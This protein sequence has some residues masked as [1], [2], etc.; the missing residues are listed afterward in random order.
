MKVVKLNAYLLKQD[1]SMGSFAKTVGTTTATISRI[2]DGIVVPRKELMQRIHSA[3]HGAVIP[4]DLV[5]LH[6]VNP[7]VPF[8]QSASSTTDSKAHTDG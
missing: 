4:N 2:A 5:G 3:T 8:K 6:C 1:I 7:C